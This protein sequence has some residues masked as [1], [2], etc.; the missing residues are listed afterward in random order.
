MM[1]GVLWIFSLV[2]DPFAQDWPMEC[3]MASNRAGHLESW[4]TTQRKA[5]DLVSPTIVLVLPGYVNHKC[6]NGN[7]EGFFLQL[8]GEGLGPSQHV[9]ERFGDLFLVHS[10]KLT[11]KAPENRPKPPKAGTD[12]LQTIKFR[13]ELLVSGSRYI[14][15]NTVD[16]SEI[17]PS[18][19]GWL[20]VH[21]TIYEVFE[22][23][24][25]YP[26]LSQVGALSQF[27][28]RLLRRS[29]VGWLVVYPMIYKGFW[30]IQPV[31]SLKLT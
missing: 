13:G 21:T 15:G 23:S 8:D 4:L 22:T 17:R 11:E 2:V 27:Y 24:Q 3:S 9:D 18:P 12:R 20:V 28:P 5:M 19:V 31:P 26:I 25:W 30:N 6:S 10:Q 29:P 16:A 14:F 1:T 7:F